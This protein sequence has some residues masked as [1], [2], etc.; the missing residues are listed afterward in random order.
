M[1]TSEECAAK[2]GGKNHKL[3]TQELNVLGVKKSP[4]HKPET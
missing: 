2:K 4:P 1:S 3:S